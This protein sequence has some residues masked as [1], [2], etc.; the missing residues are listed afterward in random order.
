MKHIGRIFFIE[1]IAVHS[2][3][4]C[5]LTLQPNSIQMSTVCIRSHFHSRP[6]IPRPNNR[7]SRAYTLD[8]HSQ[9][10]YRGLVLV[11]LRPF[12]RSNNRWRPP[13][14]DWKYRNRRPL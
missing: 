2:I 9:P 4:H 7:R 11:Q 14:L 10:A 6:G 5:N 3:T 12:C 1:P 8:C 13:F